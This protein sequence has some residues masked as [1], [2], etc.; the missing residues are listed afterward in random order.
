[1]VAELL[2]I[3]NRV[4]EAPS[5]SDGLERKFR[6]QHK[7]LARKQRKKAGTTTKVLI[8]EGTRVMKLL[9]PAGMGVVGS[10]GMG[11]VG[12][13]GPT[14]ALDSSSMSVTM[15]QEQHSM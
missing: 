15:W 7:L 5:T 2:P 14:A 9:V 10:I 3:S 6:A 12:T 1:M 8:E 13:V 11:T 4:L